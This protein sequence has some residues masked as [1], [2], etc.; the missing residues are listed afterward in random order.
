MALLLNRYKGLKTSSLTI[1]KSFPKQISVSFSSVLKRAYQS[2]RLPS[3]RQSEFTDGNDHEGDYDENVYRPLRFP[4][5]DIN[6]PFYTEKR[7]ILYSNTQYSKIPV[8]PSF[9]SYDFLSVFDNKIKLCESLG[10][11]NDYEFKIIKLNALNEILRTCDNFNRLP[12]KTLMELLKMVEVHLFREKVLLEEKYFFEDDLLPIDDY[13]WEFISICFSIL[14]YILKNIQEFPEVVRKELGS[15]FC[16]KLIDYFERPDLNERTML[17]FIVFQVMTNQHDIT[18]VDVILKK[19]IKIF[20]DYVSG[21]IS[22]LGVVPAIMIFYQTNEKYPDETLKYYYSHFIKLIT[23]KHFPS[24]QLYFT[25]PYES[26]I[27]KKSN[28]A[29]VVP[30]IQLFIRYWPQSCANKEACFLTLMTTALSQ[31]SIYDFQKIMRRV[32]SIYAR[33]MCSKNSKVASTACN[34]WNMLQLE[35][36]IMDRSKIIF[37]IIFHAIYPSI[38]E[39][40][41][42][43][44]REMLKKVLESLN[45]IDPMV[46]EVLKRTSDNTTLDGHCLKKWV[47]IAKSAYINDKNV[48]LDKK[49]S[50]IQ[51]SYQNTHILIPQFNL[52]RPCKRWSF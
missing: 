4:V 1:V 22:P 5:V 6:I 36:M 43:E 34:I 26:I 7:N 9:D 44:I 18:L 38:K 35:P 28:N 29:L 41:S 48:A 50:E 11:L 49:I 2:S 14:S 20:D 21:L 46:Y 52:P 42:S 31:I 25:P 51:V 30:T 15:Q 10:D 13:S 16:I 40:W 39:H 32:F 47:L 37:P 45:R 17:A 12:E 24:F 23:T 8:L 27:K 19:I 33:C 3:L